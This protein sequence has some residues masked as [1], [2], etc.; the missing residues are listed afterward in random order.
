MKQ[1]N[2]TFEYVCLRTVLIRRIHF[3]IYCSRK[4]SIL[5]KSVTL[6]FWIIFSCSLTSFD[7]LLFPSS[8]LAKFKYIRQIFSRIFSESALYNNLL[9]QNLIFSFSLANCSSLYLYFQRNRLFLP[10][11]FS[12]IAPSLYSPYVSQFISLLLYFNL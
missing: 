5:W 12:K 8:K 6:Y 7:H 2:N 10:L 9:I 3:Q 4:Q 11:D 1:I